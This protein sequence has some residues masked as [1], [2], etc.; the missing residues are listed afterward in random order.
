MSRCAFCDGGCACHLNPPCS[1]CT[2]H[3]ECEICGQVCCTDKL[4]ELKSQSDGSTILV[5]PD[6]VKGVD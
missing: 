4:E 2:D 3:S 6:C 1:F 5:C